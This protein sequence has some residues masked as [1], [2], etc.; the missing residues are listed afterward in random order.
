MS[1]CKPNHNIAKVQDPLDEEKAHSRVWQDGSPSHRGASVNVRVFYAAAEGFIQILD[2][3]SQDA[4]E[5]VLRDLARML[6]PRLRQLLARLEGACEA[7]SDAKSPC[8]S[9]SQKMG[10]TVPC[11]QL[12]AHLNGTFAGKLHGEMTAG[13]DLDEIR[14]QGGSP[15]GVD[16]DE[17]A[18]RDDHGTFGRIRR[19]QSFDPMEQYR[20]CWDSLSEEQKE[21][22]RLR[23]GQGR[24]VKEVAE[25]L[26]KSPSTVST[27]LKRARK[28]KEE[29][30][31][32][33]W[34]AQRRVSRESSANSDEF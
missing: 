22:V 27:L 18:S 2:T 26:D 14:A 1:Q 15:E 17:Q 13:I 31:E 9:C 33:M 21:V 10:C 34:R 6:S 32:E 19:V 12:E 30:R 8:D 29:H 25:I 23:H 3:V 24:K 16:G 4:S 7:E 11:E 28:V 5:E 20:P